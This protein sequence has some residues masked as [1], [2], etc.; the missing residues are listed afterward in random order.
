MAALGLIVDKAREI[1]TA[2]LGVVAFPEQDGRAL[3][4]ALASGVDAEAHRGLVL[5]GRGR[6]WG[7]R[8]TFG[9]P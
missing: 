4:V 5:P 6:S 7:R 3:H 2:D 9:S 8:S 1:L